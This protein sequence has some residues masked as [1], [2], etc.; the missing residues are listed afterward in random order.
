MS[1]F[2][3]S[4]A[5]RKMASKWPTQV[6]TLGKDIFIKAN[7]QVIVW[8]DTK[9]SASQSLD[10]C[11]RVSCVG[12]WFPGWTLNSTEAHQELAWAFYQE[13]PLLP[14]GGYQLHQAKKLC[15]RPGF[16]TIF[17]LYHKWSTH[18][19]MGSILHTGC[20]GGGQHEGTLSMILMILGKVGPVLCKGNK[21]LWREEARG[22]RKGFS[23]LQLREGG[24][25]GRREQHVQR[26]RGRIVTLCLGNLD[27]L[28]EGEP[29]DMSER[30]EEQPETWFRSLKPRRT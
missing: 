7:G 16:G 6:S 25:P 18:T 12:G 9:K 23:G 30:W 21:M 2:Y 5:A 10:S 27:S 19:S 17:L 22:R 1:K 8:V 24:V 13:C 4:C 26:Y 15:P 28:A 14:E 11:V 3:Y 29:L 20:H